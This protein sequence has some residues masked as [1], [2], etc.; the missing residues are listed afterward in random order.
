MP[1]AAASGIVLLGLLAQL[2]ADQLRQGFHSL[3]GVGTV[4]QKGQTFFQ[5][6]LKE[7]VALDI[8]FFRRFGI[9]L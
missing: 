3:L 2:I 8:A 7:F 9:I 4:G 5:T 1:E 6:L